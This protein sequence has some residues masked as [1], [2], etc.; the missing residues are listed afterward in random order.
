MT[1]LTFD[2]NSVSHRLTQY[3]H[4]H[5]TPGLRSPDDRQRFEAEIFS[6]WSLHT[7]IAQRK[8]DGQPDPDLPSFNPAFLIVDLAVRGE[9]DEACWLAFIAVHF[10]WDWD[11]DDDAA[12]LIRTFYSRAGEGGRWEWQAAR[13]SPQALESWIAHHAKRLEAFDFG[14]HRQHEQIDGTAAVFKSFIDWVSSTRRDGPYAALSSRMGHGATAEQA[15]DNIY[16]AFHVHQFARL[17]KFDYLIMLKALGILNIRPR[18]CYLDGATG[19]LQGANL[20]FAGKRQRK[21]SAVLSTKVEHLRA[22]LGIEPEIMEDAL[23]N[24]QKK[25]KK[26]HSRQLVTIKT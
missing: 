18:D 5:K 10:G 2:R 23:C 4:D 20:L 12:N 13:N 11:P 25:P 14:N 7:T 9:L 24:W 16:R 15:F 22:F 17:G 8:F 21:C 3:F 1:A 26:L 19:P 6:S